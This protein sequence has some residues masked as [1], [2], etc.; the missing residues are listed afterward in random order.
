[1]KDDKKLYFEENL[2]EDERVGEVVELDE[3]PIVLWLPE[4]TVEAQIEAKIYHNGKVQTATKKLN[5][6][7][8]RDGFKDAEEN[9]FDP[10]AKYVLTEKGKEWLDSLESEGV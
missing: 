3:L 10:N 4:C 7:E 1:M 2:A 5:M 8:V 6:N 9:Y